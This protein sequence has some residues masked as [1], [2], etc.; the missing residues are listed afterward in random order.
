MRAERSDM[1]ASLYLG[2]RRSATMPLHLP[3]PTRLQCC[4]PGA[5]ADRWEHIRSA[6]PIWYLT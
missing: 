2:A 5:T 4:Q 3:M 6:Q 1:L